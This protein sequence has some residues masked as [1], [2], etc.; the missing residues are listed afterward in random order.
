M[1]IIKR[2]LVVF[3]LLCFVS[4]CKMDKRVENYNE[5]NTTIVFGKA[6][7]GI[8]CY[9]NILH[10]DISDLS[11]LMKSGSVSS[12]D[13]LKMFSIFAEKNE[14]YISKGDETQKLGDDCVKIV[15]NR[16]RKINDEWISLVMT[17]KEKP[18]M[19]FYH[20]L[21]KAING[22]HLKDINFKEIKSIEVI[23][24]P[25]KVSGGEPFVLIHLTK[26]TEIEQ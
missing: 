16:L 12:E 17:K 21:M 26:K 24:E 9:E 10:F 4:A 5:S 20:G 7:S 19:P 14:F 2:N 8:P 22:Q 11:F 15:K 25:Y 3:F 6:F 1:S 18:R 23:L 13:F